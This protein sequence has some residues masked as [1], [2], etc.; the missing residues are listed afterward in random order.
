MN[1]I[2]YILKIKKDLMNKNKIII[3]VLLITISSNLFSQSNNFKTV[4]KLVEQR[5]YLSAFNE[6]S[7]MNTNGDNVEVLVTQFR[8]LPKYFIQSTSHEMFIFKDLK[9]N[10]DIM[11]MRNYIPDGNYSYTMFD[12]IKIYNEYNEKYTKSHL[13]DLAYGEFIE[14]AIYRYGDK[15]KIKPEQAE[16][17]IISLYKSAYESDVYSDK[18]LAKLGDLYFHDNDMTNAKDFYL[19]SINLNI[20]NAHSHYSVAI[21]YINENDQDNFFKHI[22]NA[23]KYY[24]HPYFRENSYMSAV[25]A[26]LQVK[27]DIDLAINYLIEGKKEFPKGYKFPQNLNYLYLNKKQYSNA[28]EEADYLFSLA[29][30]NPNS[31]NIIIENYNNYSLSNE[32]EKFFIRNLKIYKNDQNALGNLNYHLGRIYKESNNKEAAIKHLDLAE[33]NFIS[34]LGDG[35]EVLSLIKKLKNELE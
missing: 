2:L 23:I 19:R 25:Q 33:I 35:A 27:N 5:K 26:S 6:L 14:D 18:S 30:T 24:E 12:P 20:E 4:N 8:F 31:T 34:S 11:E 9:S 7:K 16:K 29:P 28:A 10:D 32:L 3:Y 15:W 1:T 21:I 22:N 17:E 13:L